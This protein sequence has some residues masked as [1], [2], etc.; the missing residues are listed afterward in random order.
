MAC[1]IMEETKIIQPYKTLTLQKVRT[2]TSKRFQALVQDNDM[3]DD[4]NDDDDDDI[5]LDIYVGRDL[6]IVNKDIATN[7]YNRNVPKN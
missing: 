3:D 5:D 7:V 4:N 2:P 1:A 6:D